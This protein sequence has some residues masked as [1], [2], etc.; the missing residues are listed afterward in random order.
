MRER[1]KKRKSEIARDV[2]YNRVNMAGEH[3][4]LRIV[5]HVSVSSY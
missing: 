1:K 2:S 3:G 4:I 5:M